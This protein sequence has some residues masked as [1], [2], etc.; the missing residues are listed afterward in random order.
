MCAFEVQYVCVCFCAS[1]SIS[2]SVSHSNSLSVCLYIGL[3]L[4]CGN[5]FFV[6]SCFCAKQSNSESVIWSSQIKRIPIL[7]KI[8]ARFILRLRC[9]ICYCLAHVWPFKFAL[10]IVQQEKNIIISIIVIIAVLTYSEPPS[11]HAPPNYFFCYKPSVPRTN[12]RE[13]LPSSFCR[14]IILSRR[15]T[16]KK[17]FL[18]F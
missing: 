2:Q 18:V 16:P 13:F 14:K 7:N 17:C 11:P 8:R 4:L 10:G 9:L 5:R 3:A 6:L 1:Q 12:L 15:P